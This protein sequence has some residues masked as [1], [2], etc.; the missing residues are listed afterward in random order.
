MN[1]VWTFGDSFTFGDGCNEWDDYYKNYPKKRGL[2]F[3]KLLSNHYDL[4]LEDFSRNGAPNPWILRNIVSNIHRFE[5]G[6]FVSINISDSF[7][8][9]LPSP[10]NTTDLQPILNQAAYKENPVYGEF[11]SD[12]DV[13]TTV[14]QYIKYLHMMD[15]NDS[16][17]NKNSVGYKVINDL[18]M[19]QFNSIKKLLLKLG[20]KV[21]MW[22]WEDDF[23]RKYETITKCTNNKIDNYHLSWNG[24]RQLA[25]KLIKSFH[26]GITTIKWK[27]TML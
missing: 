14:Y 23:V 16:D 9:E 2:K 7:R 10:S 4:P 17:K 15:I 12:G 3:N 1:K 19:N 26:K 27:N 11:D 8:F 22:D 5:K 21:V 18:H 25:D 13:N 6:D 20:V 24:H